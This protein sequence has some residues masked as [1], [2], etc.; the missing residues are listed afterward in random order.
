[1]KIKCSS[2][3]QVTRIA[4]EYPYHA[5]FSSRVFLYCDSCPAILELSSYDSKF[6]AVIGG[7]DP[8]ALS[9][10]E[11]KRVE[12]ALKPC[13]KGGRFRFDALP[14]CPA[15]NALLPDLLKDNLHFIEIGEVTDADKEDVWLSDF[16]SL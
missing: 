8:W 12:N 16:P 10:E 7:K 9:S 2:C 3:G 5:G 13:E 14:R 6:N 11:K 1:M 4:Q 15:C